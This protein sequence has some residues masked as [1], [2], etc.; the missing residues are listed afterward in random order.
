MKK[1]KIIALGLVLTMALTACGKQS[2]IGADGKDNY[3]LKIGETQGALCHAPLQI[4]MEKGYLDEEGVKWERVDFGG[5]DI[6]AALGAGTID[7][8]FGLIGKFIQPIENGLNMVVTSGMHTGCTKIMVREDSG[9]NS[10]A[11]LKGKTVGVSSLAGSEAVTA[12]RAAYA[13][14]LNISADGGDIDFAV[15]GTTDQ[16]IALLNGAV[17]AIATPD[18]V[19]TNAEV[20]YGF[21]VLLDTATTEPYA[22]EYCC[23]SFISTE[24][25]KEHPQ[26]AAA[27][28]RAV[29]KAS[30]WV[31]EHPEEAA[32]IQIDGE[33]VSGDVDFNASI[34]SSYKFIPSVQGGYDALVNVSG[35]L[36]KIG[37]LKETTDLDSMIKRSFQFFDD[38]PDSY[39]I[40]NDQFIAVK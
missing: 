13:A 11:D 37:I 18:P 3:V 35:D 36:K 22:S 40:E 10:I 6:Q 24:V 2:T 28:T 17:D 31:A 32:Q 4:A 8:G 15:Y 30:A 23:V 29:L 14:G 21:K 20:E 9:I 39:T 38:V 12:K 5:S 33:Y 1:I 19:A 7:A 34:L 25:A 16:P 26:V 27:F